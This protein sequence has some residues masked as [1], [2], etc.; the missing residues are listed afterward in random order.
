MKLSTKGRYAV[1]AM[2]AVA[3]GEKSKPVTLAE[4][5]E[6]QGISI[7]YLEQIF[8]RLR[9]NLLVK[10]TRGPGGGYCLSREPQ[11]I[12]I[13]EIIIAVED[14]L[15][16]QKPIGSDHANPRSSLINSM[17][18]NL[19]QRI[20]SLLREVTVADLLYGKYD[21]PQVF[22]QAQPLPVMQNKQSWIIDRPT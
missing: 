9:K 19:S 12:S 8:S 4:I 17:W 1:T 15:R 7:S 10:G 18:D 16:V 2:M 22:A 20:Q 6:E 13:A 3:I 5:S 11:S 14:Q 21:D